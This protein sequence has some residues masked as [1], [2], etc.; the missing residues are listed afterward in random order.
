MPYDLKPIDLDVETTPYLEGRENLPGDRWT[1]NFGP[2]HPA[3][4]TTLRIVM[5][6]DG[7]RIALHLA[8]ACGGQH[9]RGQSHDVTHQGERCAPLLVR[10]HLEEFTQ[11][12]SDHGDGA[13]PGADG[14]RTY[15]HFQARVP[16][17][18]HR[19]HL[20]DHPPGKGRLNGIGEGD[21]VLGHARIVAGVSRTGRSGH[22][23]RT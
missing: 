15:P 6:L 14:L 18:R 19:G 16:G 10:V 4:H 9:L 8:D 21:A 11:P 20:A 12:R 5:E 23:R 3:T 1:L 13:G 7:E 22:G 2:Q 17:L